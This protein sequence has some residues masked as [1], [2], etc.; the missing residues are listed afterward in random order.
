MMPAEIWYLQQQQQMAQQAALEQE[1]RWR[2]RGL[3]LL[4]DG[5]ASMTIGSSN[6]AVGP[7][8]G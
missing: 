7:H 1:R 6:D 2:A 8:R 3:L 4:A 5:T